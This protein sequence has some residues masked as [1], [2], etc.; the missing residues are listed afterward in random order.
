MSESNALQIALHKLIWPWEGCKLEAYWDADGEV[1]TI[2]RGHTNNVSQGDTCTQA[3]ADAWSTIDACWAFHAVKYSVHVVLNENQF[4]ALISFEYNTGAFT[5]GAPIVAR[6]NANDFAGAME[7]LMLYVNGANGFVQGLY[8][9]RLA[10]KA[11]F[12]S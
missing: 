4:A 6:I 10:E 12:E 7:H 1:W 3:Q 8:N 2:G 5:E 9:R 11:L